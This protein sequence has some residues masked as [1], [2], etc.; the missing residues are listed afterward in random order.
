MSLT[1]DLS[2]LILPRY[3]GHLV[4]PM[5][6]KLPLR[7]GIDSREWWTLSTFIEWKKFSM[8]ALSQ[9]SPFRLIEQTKPCSFWEFP[10]SLCTEFILFI[11]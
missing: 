1:D 7:P 6:Q 4:K 10:P 5:R 9:Q 2:A 8:A 3:D 11:Q